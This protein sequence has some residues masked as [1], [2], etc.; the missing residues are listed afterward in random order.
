MG[1]A[2]AESEANFAWLDLPDGADEAEVMRGLRDR[3]VLVRRG[4]ALGR[5]GALRVTYGTS[6][7][8]ARFLAAFAELVS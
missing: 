6:E 3:G 8:N 2:F 5:D 1:I 7:Q 4:S